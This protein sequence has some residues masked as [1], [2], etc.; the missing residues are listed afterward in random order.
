MESSR[1]LFPQARAGPVPLAAEAIL[2][3]GVE[4]PPGEVLLF[5]NALGRK[6]QPLRQRGPGSGQMSAHLNFVENTTRCGARSPQTQF[7][8]RHCCSRIPRARKC[9]ACCSASAPTSRWS[10]TTRSFRRTAP[11]RP[12]AYGRHLSRHLRLGAHAWGDVAAGAQSLSTPDQ[13]ARAREAAAADLLSF[14]P[15]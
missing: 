12:T 9:T 4:L 8:K 14:E 10:R 3:G 2:P 13:Q 6:T 1:A 5:R 7:Q 11:H 15:V